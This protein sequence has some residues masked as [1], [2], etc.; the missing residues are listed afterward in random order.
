AGRLMEMTTAEGVTQWQY[1]IQ[2]RVVCIDSPEGVLCYGYD[3]RGRVVREE[4]NGRVT[5]REYP[6]A[7][8]ML[9]RIL[10]PEGEG[11]TAQEAT[12]RVNYA[13]ELTECRLSDTSELAL[14]YNGQGRESRRS[15]ETGFVLAQEYDATGKLVS[16]RAGCETGSDAS[17]PGGTIRTA[18]WRRY[19]YDGAQN[20]VAVNDDHQALRYVMNGN[21]QVTAVMS[22]GQARERYG[23]DECGY[24]AQQWTGEKVSLLWDNHY[25]RGHRLTWHGDVLAE[26][27]DAGRMTAQSI[28]R[29]GHRPAVMRFRWDSQDRL[30]GLVNWRGEQWEYRYDA[31]G[32][33]TEK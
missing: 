33:R 27:D 1:D 29:K 13:G 8:T 30:T 2:G 19:E 14:E 9:R 31:L 10:P 20:V 18:L 16:Q 32:R 11:T 7:R 15:C 6:Q 21:G 12:F 24:L 25:T 28:T 17:M 3:E 4:Q 5:E 23:Y 26:Y 22:H